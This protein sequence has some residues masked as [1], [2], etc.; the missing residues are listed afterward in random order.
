MTMKLSRFI[1]LVLLSVLTTAQIQAQNTQKFNASKDNEYGL[2]YTLPRTVIDITIETEHTHFVP[3]EF[4]NYASRHLAI[5][6][7]ITEETTTVGIRSISFSTRGV[8]NPE[9]QWLVQFKRGSSVSMTLTPDGVP[10]SINTDSITSVPETAYIEAEIAEPTILETD[11]I[12]HAMTQDMIMSSS[13]SKRAELAA[14]RIFELREKRDEL[15]SGEYE[16]P[17]ADGKAMELVLDNLAAQEDA[18]T[19]MFVG[20]EK[21]WTNVKT[22]SLCPSDDVEREVIARISPFDGILDPDNLAGSPL[23]IS[24]EVLERGEIPLTA[25]GM[26]K[27]FPKGGVAYSI[28]GKAHIV[29]SYE[30]KTV[31]DT[32]VTLS[33][34]GCVF[35]IDPSLFSDKKAPSMLRLD[36]ATGAILYLGP[37]I[38]NA[39]TL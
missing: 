35:G 32:E 29:V 11:A 31:A 13:I 2:R 23:T 8:A 17:P 1:L 18:L 33:Q 15:L 12:R 21:T 39:T 20:T 25:E 14:A 16:N 34:L 22:I 30:G 24:V 3:G 28:P 6:N 5:N 37:I 4:Y 38:H 36:P 10:L 27:S 19:A 7:A 9:S 26:P